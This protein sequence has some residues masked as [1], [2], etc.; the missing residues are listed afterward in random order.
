M[1]LFM[2]ITHSVSLS[3]LLLPVSF[4]LRCVISTFE[5]VNNNN[6]S[7]WGGIFSLPPS[8]FSHIL[9]THSIVMRAVKNEK[10]VVYQSAVSSGTFLVWSSRF[11]WSWLLLFC[12]SSCLYVL[13]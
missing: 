2:L 1:L 8:L 12:F 4:F 3:L 7:I 9:T 6:L 10:S 11:V 13:D 5:C